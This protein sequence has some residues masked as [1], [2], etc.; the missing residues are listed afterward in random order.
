ML[1]LSPEFHIYGP[2]AFI[3]GGVEIKP[4]Y[5]SS[6][7][8]DEMPKV[9]RSIAN[10]VYQAY[11]INTKIETQPKKQILTKLSPLTASIDDNC[12]DH[13]ITNKGNA[14]GNERLAKIL[15]LRLMVQKWHT[16]LFTRED[17]FY[18]AHRLMEKFDPE[19]TEYLLKAIKATILEFT[20]NK[21]RI[22]SNISNNVLKVD[23]E[24]IPPE[25]LY[26]V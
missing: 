16:G 17:G 5:T 21:F 20:Y 25:T 4:P 9:I 19:T 3:F 6:D 26:L 22:G 13:Q 11:G 23:A 7:V 8:I 18:V 14:T 24:I 10:S 15:Y 1:D 12:I 2:P